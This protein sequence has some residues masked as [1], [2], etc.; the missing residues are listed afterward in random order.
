MLHWFQDQRLI[1]PG[2]G[3]EKGVVTQVS[4]G[5]DLQVLFTS[6]LASLL[7]IS[8]LVVVFLAFLV[9]RI[10]FFWGSHPAKKSSS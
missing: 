9:I 7:L 1:D 8:P 6:T 5:S 2:A 10:L 4:L 3:R